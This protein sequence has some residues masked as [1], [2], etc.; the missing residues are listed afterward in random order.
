MKGMYGVISEL[1]IAKIKGSILKM[2]IRL[3]A[4]GNLSMMAIV[5]PI[6]RS[7]Q[8]KKGKQQ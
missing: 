4:F 8:R 1:K 7:E 6:S 2:N 3:G 5:P